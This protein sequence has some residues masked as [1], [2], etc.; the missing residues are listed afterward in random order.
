MKT[1]EYP[2]ISLTSDLLGR[3]LVSYGV[4]APFP[5]TLAGCLAWVKI[6][7]RMTNTKLAE[8]LQINQRSVENYLQGRPVAL[9]VLLQIKARLSAL[10]EGQSC[11][12]DEVTSFPMP[13]PERSESPSIKPEKGKQESKRERASREKGKQEKQKVRVTNVPRGTRTKSVVAKGARGTKGKGGVR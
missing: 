7:E 2:Q 11:F 6:N 4:T 5:Q 8:W 12:P 10:A 9:P 3:P 1:K 13:L